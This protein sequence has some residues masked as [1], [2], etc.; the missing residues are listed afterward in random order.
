MMI[1]LGLQ[2]AQRLAFTSLIDEAIL[3]SKVDLMVIILSLL[4]AAALVSSIC[5][6]LHEYL[7]SGLCAVMPAELRKQLF[8]RVQGLELASIRSSTHGDLVSRIINDAGGLES[9]LWSLG[10]IAT[11]F[12]GV[13]IALIML[14]ITDWRL[15]ILG[16]LLLVPTIPIGP[17][18]LTPI[19]EQ[20]SYESKQAHGRLSN[21]LWENLANQVVVRVFG[22][23]GYVTKRF[24]LVNHDIQT[25]T[26]KYNIYSYFSNRVPWIAVEFIDVIVLACGCWML[27]KGHITTGA[28]VSFYLLFAALATHAYSF[29]TSISRLVGLS[30][31]MRRVEEFQS[32]ASVRVASP[33]RALLPPDADC[34]AISLGGI[35]LSVDS[36]SSLATAPRSGEL[37]AEPACLPPSIRFSDV[38]YVYPNTQFSA[39]L[40]FELAAGKLTAFVGSS[41]SGKSTAIQLLLGLITPQRG[42]IW[43]NGETLESIGFARYWAQTSAVFQDSLLF[44]GSIAENIRTGFLDASDQEIADAAHAAGLSDWIAGLP[45]GD[46]TIVSADSCSGGQ[47]Q[48]IAIARALIRKP[49]LLVLDEP[50]SALDTST[51]SAVMNTL[52][53]L[54]NQRSTVLVTHRLYDAA[55]ADWILVFDQGRVVQSGVHEALLEQDGIYQ[56]LWKKQQDLSQSKESVPSL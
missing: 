18:I 15:A 14:V 47:R 55:K 51:A 8:L 10:Y 13:L 2:M 45:M 56:A 42:T 49:N 16:L 5:G 27:I 52:L 28:L 37:K 43:V 30:A 1:E 25:S 46:E 38:C 21:Q 12:F 39:D 24:D 9:A 36:D 23:A 54:A 20:A 31:S 11:G 7:L 29:A 26:R 34:H 33:S 44:H 6:S 4:F 53:Q 40:S 19:A 3:Q 32:M 22:L 35:G 41:G 50:T 48:R 17:R